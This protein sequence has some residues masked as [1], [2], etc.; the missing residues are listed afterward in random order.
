MSAPIQGRT[1]TIITTVP[2]PVVLANVGARLENLTVTGGNINKTESLHGA[3][4]QIGTFGGTASGCRITGNRSGTYYN[5]GGGVGIGSAQGVVRNCII[6]HNTVLCTSSQEY[7]G[8]AYLTAGVMSNCVIHSNVSLDGGGV[9]IAGEALVANCTIV[10]NRATNAYGGLFMTDWATANVRAK[11]RDSI[12]WGNVDASTSP[13]DGTTTRPEY[14]AGAVIN[15]DNFNYCAFSEGTKL[16][17]DDAR[18][19]MGE[20][21]FTCNPGFKRFDKLDF[22]IKMFSP[23][24]RVMG[25]DGRYHGVSSTGSWLGALQPYPAGFLL[26]VK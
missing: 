23:C 20:G 3:G 6:D 13:K 19:L 25:D 8:G 4:L 1:T 5:C 18:H 9:Y 26:L 10:S 14:G 21:N 16:P 11:V 24:D 12:I 15:N 7:G 22:R 17:T 2:P